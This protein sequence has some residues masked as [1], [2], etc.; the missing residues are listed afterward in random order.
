LKDAETKIEKR[1][2][3]HRIEPLTMFIAVRNARAILYR[4]FVESGDI[5]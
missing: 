4:C 1:N 2:N 3:A 5:K